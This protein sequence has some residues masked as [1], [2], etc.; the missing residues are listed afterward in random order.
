MSAKDQQILFRDEPPSIRALKEFFIDS[1]QQSVSADMLDCAAHMIISIESPR[2]TVRI[3]LEYM[4]RTLSVCRAD[5]GFATPTDSEYTPLAQ[6]LNEN[7]KPPTLE[8]FVISNQHEC[9]QRIWREKRPV[10]YE[11]VNSNPLLEGVRE[12]LLETGTQS[13]LM[14]R[15]VW[16]TEP[17]G[18]S[19][20]DHTRVNH[21][22]SEA[23]VDFMH[24][25]CSLFFAPLA[26]ISNYWFNPSLHQMF[27]KPS[28]SE[29]AAIRLAAQ[30]MSYK[31]IAGQLNKSIRTIDNQLRHARQRL[32][33]SNQIELI[34]K[35]APWLD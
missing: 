6:Y 13:M 1:R 16:D 35:C 19:C 33:V 29:L 26:G 32:N 21:H 8:H 2:D 14:Q 18:I 11:A 7:T 17:I 30:G 27:K 5:A 4:G 15:L 3:A 34:K 10:R 25:F 12:A 22:W 9:M 20:V 31:Q 23:E 24:Q 28:E